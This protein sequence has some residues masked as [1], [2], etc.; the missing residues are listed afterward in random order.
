MLIGI[1]VIDLVLNHLDSEVEVL[2]ILL[3]ETTQLKYVF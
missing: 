2:D 1:V 3:N